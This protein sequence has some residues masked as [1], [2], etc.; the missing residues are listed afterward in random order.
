MNKKKLFCFLV[1]YLL[2]KLAQPL[3]LPSFVIIGHGNEVHG[4]SHKLYRF[5]YRSLCK[6]EKEKEKSLLVEALN[7][8]SDDNSNINES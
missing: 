3:R 2:L 5:L 8:N 6:K 1:I 7:S 4:V